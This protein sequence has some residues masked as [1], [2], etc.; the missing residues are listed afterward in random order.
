MKTAAEILQYIESYYETVTDIPASFFTDVNSMEAELFTLEQLYEFIVDDSITSR[1][2]PERYCQ[3]MHDKGYG[4]L[5]FYG[6]KTD[7]DDEEPTPR[8]PMKAPSDIEV[9]EMKEFGKLLREYL[10]SGR[11]LTA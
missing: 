8:R 3:F 9:A 5:G 7:E 1:G 10:M 2:V 11:R 4:S 6:G